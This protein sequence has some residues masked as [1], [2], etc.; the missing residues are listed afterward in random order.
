VA[1]NGDFLGHRRIS[2]NAKTLGYAVLTSILFVFV[3]TV[4]RYINAHKATGVARLRAGGYSLMLVGFFTIML[5]FL[6]SRLDMVYSGGR[7]N[8]T[9]LR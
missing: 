9:L 7:V 5:G 3:R 1:T 6:L 4:V 2:E 8:V